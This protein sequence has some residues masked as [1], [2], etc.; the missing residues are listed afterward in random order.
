[1]MLWTKSNSLK[2]LNLGLMNI[3]QRL[4][5]IGPLAPRWKPIGWAGVGSEEPEK[6]K[7]HTKPKYHLL[8]V[9]KTILL[10]LLLLSSVLVLVLVFSIVLLVLSLVT[11][12]KIGF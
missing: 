10:L 9:F 3:H 7:E 8:V 2:G 12:G 11:R 4:S 1:M 6:V 5:L